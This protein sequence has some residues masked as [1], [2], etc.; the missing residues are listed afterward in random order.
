MAAPEA[1]PAAAT[2]AWRVLVPWG[3][4]GALLVALYAPVLSALAALSQTEAAY[5]HGLLIPLIAAYL[6]WHKRRELGEVPRRPCTAAWPFLLL[7]V[8]VLAV[9]RLTF[10]IHAAALSFVI[11]LG[12]L[13]AMAGGPRLLRA[14]LFP[15]AYL[16]FMVPL[17]WALY[18]G[19]GDPLE[20]ATAAISARLVTPLGIPLF[21]EGTLISLPTVTLEVEASCSGVRTALSLLPLAAAFAYLMVRRPRARALL[22]ASAL[23]IAI[24][25]N[26]L[27]VVAI[28]IQAYLY[29][30]LVTGY[31]LHLYTNWIPMLLGLP[32]LFAVGGLVQCWETRRAS[33][34]RS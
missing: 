6:V 10:E 8:L 23:P 33:G 25:V 22:V 13:V 18:F 16:I 34:S 14:L 20:T 31:A 11:V 17:P 15:L 3:L 2:R 4:L 5:S 19:A 30:S 12:A 28:I 21:R 26:I 1:V 9:G 7:G 24:L 32:M 27:R 29:P